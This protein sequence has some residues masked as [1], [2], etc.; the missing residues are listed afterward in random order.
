MHAFSDLRCVHSRSGNATGGRRIWRLGTRRGL[1]SLSRYRP[2]STSALRA[3]AR[4]E[5][6]DGGRGAGAT[7]IDPAR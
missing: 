7:A 6:L 5:A 3:L 2:A 4:L 1:L